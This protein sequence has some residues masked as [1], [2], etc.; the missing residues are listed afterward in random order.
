MW[1]VMVLV[2]RQGVNRGRFVGGVMVV[3]MVRSNPHIHVE[4]QEVGVVVGILGCWVRGASS[5]VVCGRES[6][7]LHRNVVC[8]WC[9][10][11]NRLADISLVPPGF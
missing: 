9:G 7:V 4:F 11:V 6:S 2:S 5:G 1:C 8:S 10:V 3:G